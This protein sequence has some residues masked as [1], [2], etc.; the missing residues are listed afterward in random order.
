[1]IRENLEK[2][3]N[4]IRSAQAKSPYGQDVTLIAVSKTKPESDIMQAYEAGIRDFGENKVQELCAKYD[5]L[6]KDIR[7]HLIGHL[8]TNKVKYIIGKTYLIHS[9]D[10]LKLA[11]EIEKEAAKKDVTVDILIQVNI[12]GEESK[13]GISCE[14]APG[15]YK[16]I[17]EMPHINIKGFMTIAPICD[18][19]EEVRPVFAELK[20]LSVDIGKASGDNTLKYEL[21]MG[22]SGDFKAAVLEGATYVRIGSSIFGARNY[23]LK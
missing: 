13:S 22:M 7:W 11:K 3:K 4:E 21:S 17:S 5:D 16:M 8:Q 19:Q 20:K 2:I 12:S 14:E 9:V 10:S 6:P 15:L 18:D 23:N 1:M